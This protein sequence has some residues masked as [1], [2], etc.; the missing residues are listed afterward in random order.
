MKRGAYLLALA[1]ASLVSGRSAEAATYTL[2][3]TGLNSKIVIDSASGNIVDW[4]VEGVDQVFNR[5]Y[6]FRIGTPTLTNPELAVDDSNLNLAS[7]NQLDTNFDPGIDTVSMRFVDP[8]QTFQ[9]ITSTSLA[10]GLP[11]S[12]Q[13]T[14]TE[15]FRIDNLSRTT[16]LQISIFLYADYDLNSTDTDAGV[17]FGDPRTVS[18]GDAAG[19]LHE[20]SVTVTPA[21]IEASLY[22]ALINLLND[23][24]S[25]NLSGATSVGSGDGVYAFQWDIEIG[26][27][28]SWTLGNTNSITVPEAST[29][30]LVGMGLAGGLLVARRRTR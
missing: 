17:L 5:Q 22:P 19:V 8:N 6:F 20:S 9:I 16:A 3:D 24:A 26:P 21:L 1:A 11:G 13:T 15:S 28:R 12:N 27:R 29:T 7:V 25:D 18:Q 2:E 23:G 10:A 4:F 14:F 30:L